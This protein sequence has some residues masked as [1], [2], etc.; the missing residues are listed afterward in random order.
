VDPKVDPKPETKSIIVNST[1]QKAEV[2]GPDGAR[3]GAT[4]AL[5]EVEVGKPLELTLKRKRYQD[6]RVVVDGS[7]KKETFALRRVSSR[8]GSS[9]SGGSSGTSGGSGTGDK[10]SPKGPCAKDPSSVECR[11]EKNPN[12]P[13]CDLE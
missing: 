11:C 6:Q 12:L 2:Y 3:L 10:P 4:P 5:I 9:G 7:K 8:S 13:E 1:P